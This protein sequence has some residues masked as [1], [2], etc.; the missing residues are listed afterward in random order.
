LNNSDSQISAFDD[1]PEPDFIAAR[2]LFALETLQSLD[3]SSVGRCQAI[4]GHGKEYGIWETS[5]KVIGYRLS[6]WC[7]KVI[8]RDQIIRRLPADLP[9]TENLLELLSEAE[10]WLSRYALLLR[11]GQSSLRRN[12]RSLDPSTIIR[13]IYKSMPPLLV[14]GILARLQNPACVGLLRCI[15]PEVLPILRRNAESSQELNRVAKFYD[16]GL[17][18]DAPERET[19]NNITNPSGDKNLTPT[20]DISNPYQ[21]L[22][23]I[24]MA[25][26]GPR[27]LWVVETL[28]PELLKLGEQVKLLFKSDGCLATRNRDLANFLQRRKWNDTTGFNPWKPPLITDEYRCDKEY[29]GS[30]YSK[31]GDFRPT[32]WA[33]IVGLFI[34]LQAAHFWVVLLAT[35]GR[36]GELLNLPR[37]CIE[38]SRDGKPYLN[39]KTYKLSENLFGEQREWPA[40]DILVDTLAQQVEL[41]NSYEELVRARNNGLDSFSCGS[42][43]WISL[44]YGKLVDSKN[45]MFNV[46]YALKTLAERLGVE[47]SPAD[48]NVHA[49]RFRKTI[50]RLVALTILEGPRVLMRLL[51]HKDMSMTLNYILSDKGLQVEIDKVGRELRII[52]CTEIVADVHQGIH[53]LRGYPYSGYGGGAMPAIQD[54]VSNFEAR[55]NSQGNLWS[56]E[57]A[58][59][60]ATVLTF[61]GQDFKLIRPGVICMKPSNGFI[62]CFCNADCVN[63]IEDKTARRDVEVIIPLLIDNAKVAIRHNQLLVAESFRKQ[64]ED[65]LLRFHDIGD[66]WQK[67]P[68]VI[69]IR[70]YLEE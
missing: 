37:I 19:I 7:A 55:L 34:L 33:D 14:A 9:V 62:P 42:G 35:A 56:D 51:G 54:A 27:V 30:R 20:E 65:E 8:I 6:P 25:N 36:V 46:N 58:H 17:W 41:I 29:L 16:M 45:C 2:K 26:M 59:D 67:H 48:Q 32:C 23:D 52:R 64:L 40:P 28:G 53:G 66:P 60:L 10:L 24:Y 70:Q 11:V 21:P 13:I 44:G 39:G 31:F 4:L 38:K 57:S 5:E 3:Q 47:Q 18:S 22:S 1:A 61:N 15:K 43:L 68:D 49:H 69:Y 12:H 50:A 63:R